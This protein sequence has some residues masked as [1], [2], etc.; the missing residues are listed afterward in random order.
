MKQSNL[1]LPQEALADTV[2]SVH[3]TLEVVRKF[4]FQVFFARDPLLVIEVAGLVFLFALLGKAFS[5][6]FFLYSAFLVSFV[7]PRVYEA[8]QKEIDAAVAQALAVVS[9]KVGPL[10]EKVPFLKPKSD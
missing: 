6:L 1:G 3:L 10:L 9:A 8:K 4:S 2:Q 7:W 5:G